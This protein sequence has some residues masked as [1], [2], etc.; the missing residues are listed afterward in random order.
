M[1]ESQLLLAENCQPIFPKS[2]ANH[3]KVLQTTLFLALIN[4]AIYMLGALWADGAVVGASTPADGPA[5]NV[6]HISSCGIALTQSC[7]AAIC[8]SKLE[9]LPNTA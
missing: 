6:S 3:S 4:P 1:S 9:Q 7:K 8:G 2:S 5:S